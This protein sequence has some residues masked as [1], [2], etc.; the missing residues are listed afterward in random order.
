MIA[1]TIAIA[2]AAV[3]AYAW[4]IFPL[5]L[6]AVRDRAWTGDGPAL[7]VAVVF[8]AHNEELHVGERI[9]NLLRSGR[10]SA[11]YVGVDG[12]TDRT[13]EIARERAGGDARVRVVEHA[14][15]RGK[16]ATLKE[17]VS[18]VA[19]DVLV[20]TDANTVFEEGTLARLVA[21]LD[22]P[23]VGGTCGRLV[24]RSA[25]GGPA[26]EGVYWR[27]ETFLK[28]R[29]SALDSCLGA[30]G[31]IYAIRRELFPSAIPDNTVIDDFVIGM[32]VREQS[33]RMVYVPTAVACEEL[34]ESMSDEWRRR[35]RI[36]S[37]GY[38][39]LGLC[40]RC[41]LPRYGRFA[42][43]FWSHKVLRWFTPH[44]LLLLAAAAVGG[45]VF[46]PSGG[47]SGG[48]V[49]R[50]VPRAVLA[51]LV[52]AGLLWLGGRFARRSR[53]GGA[54]LLRQCDYFL[55]MQAALFAG[56]IRFLHGDLK[57]HWTRT[58]RSR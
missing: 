21:P 45:V 11:V 14:G 29:E 2:A 28:N 18:G 47:H 8:A 10:V 26:D 36:G 41:L 22:D 50:V 58:P 52:L 24:F 39:A 44:L 56:F 55:T 23:R 15:R 40:R 33:H 3:L 43:C 20:F 1:C 7:S 54:A 12:S 51:A 30:N 4:V 48:V 57:G 16:I 13:A 46:P 27:L 42:W 35:V 5:L 32:K 37:G 19:E 38:Q 6:L 31:A 53:G 49:T 17:L 9:D 25:T 34:P